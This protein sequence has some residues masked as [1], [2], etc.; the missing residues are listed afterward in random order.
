MELRE[1]ALAAQRRGDIAAAHR[2]DRLANEA[3][4]EER[5]QSSLA[6]RSSSPLEQDAQAFREIIA[7]PS[8]PR[9]ELPGTRMYQDRRTTSNPGITQAFRD[10]GGYFGFGKP[11]PDFIT[12]WHDIE[13][14]PEDIST[15]EMSRLADSLNNRLFFDPSI[16]SVGTGGASLLKE[17]GMGQAPK[18]ET[19]DQRQQALRRDF[20]HARRTWESGLMQAGTEYQA[21]FDLAKNVMQNVNKIFIDTQRAHMIRMEND[22]EIRAMLF[23]LNSMPQDTRTVFQ[24]G[25]DN[26]FA[27][28]FREATMELGAP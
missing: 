14:S 19:E 10:S 12:G 6:G 2:L 25:F 1:Q 11:G 22:P 28:M 20:E 15:E 27:R 17:G 13:R 5:I 16:V 26:L 9:T 4:R 23:A 8:D 21:M 18:M 7:D 3:A 24:Q